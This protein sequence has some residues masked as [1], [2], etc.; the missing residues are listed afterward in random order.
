VRE[1]KRGRER[2]KEKG[3]GLVWGGGGEGERGLYCM[4]EG[5][6]LKSPQRTRG[7]IGVGAVR[8]DGG[9]G[10]RVEATRRY[11]S[12]KPRIFRSSRIRIRSK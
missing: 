10:V 6:P 9:V 11:S 8:G 5:P 7:Q 12:T 3:G 1:S 2:E 4:P